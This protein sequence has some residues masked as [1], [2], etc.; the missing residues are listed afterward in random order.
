MAPGVDGGERVELEDELAPA[1]EGGG[2][3][4]LESKVRN[5]RADIITTKRQYT[6]VGPP[7][8]HQTS[9]KF[10]NLFHNSLSS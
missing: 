9:Q 7:E 5:Q 1:E 6:R 2:G 3:G 4:D 10:W 8:T